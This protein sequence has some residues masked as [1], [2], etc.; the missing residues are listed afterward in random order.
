MIAYFLVGILYVSG[1]EF[2]NWRRTG[3]YP[4]RLFDWT[5][6]VFWVVLWPLVIAVRLAIWFG[7]GA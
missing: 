1:S 4:H 7:E 3:V 2:L 6:I 5:E